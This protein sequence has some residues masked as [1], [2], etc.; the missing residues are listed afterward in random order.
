M[1]KFLLWLEG[2]NSSAHAKFHPP[3]PMGSKDFNYFSNKNAINKHFRKKHFSSSKELDGYTDNNFAFL[4]TSDLSYCILLAS[5]VF[6]FLISVFS[7]QC[8]SFKW[9]WLY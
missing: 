1:I 9:V 2:I 6:R 7:M 8:N 5:D 3:R 4:R